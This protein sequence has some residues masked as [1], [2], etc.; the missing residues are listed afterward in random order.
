M[1]EVSVVWEELYFMVVLG[2]CYCLLSQSS[3]VVLQHFVI[4]NLPAESR[5]QAV[6]ILTLMLHSENCLPGSSGGH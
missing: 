3:L 2:W 4:L 1:L 6:H 5:L